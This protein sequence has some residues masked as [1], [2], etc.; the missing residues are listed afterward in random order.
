MELAG[1]C[2]EWRMRGNKSL[3]SMVLFKI[4]VLSRVNPTEETTSMR[5]SPGARI[6]GLA[7]AGWP[8]GLLPLQVAAQEFHVD[9][10]RA[11]RVSFLSDAP[12]EDFEGVTDRIDGFALLSG[13]GLWGE[14]DLEA[15]EFYF[16]VDLASLDTGIGLRNRHMRRNYLETERFPFASFQGRVTHLAADGFGGFQITASGTFGIHGVD[17]PREIPCVVTPEESNLS[18]RCGFSVNLTHHNIEIPKLMFMKVGEVMEVELD[19]Y[20]E[21]ADAGGDDQ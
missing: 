14:T 5:Y 20:L 8:L 4:E 19:F 13:E 12:L 16:E 15:S 6:V 1:G 2:Q 10:D 18:V 9:L 21:P 7:V 3:S 11:N 17:R